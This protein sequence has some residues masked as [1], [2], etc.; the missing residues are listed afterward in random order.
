M[1]AACA[2]CQLSQ[3]HPPPAT[4]HPVVA[5]VEGCA[6]QRLCLDFVGPMGRSRR[7]TSTSSPSVIPLPSGSKLFPAVTPELLMSST[8]SSKKYSVASA[9]H[10]PSILIVGT[11]FVNNLVKDVAAALDIRLT[12]TTAYNPKA[13]PVERAHRDFGAH[14][15]QLS[16]DD[17]RSWDDHVPLAVFAM[18]T[19]LCRT[20]GLAP[21]QALFGR[22]PPTP[23]HILMAPPPSALPEELAAHHP[24]VLRLRERMQQMHAYMRER[25]GAAVQRQRRAYHQDARFYNIGDRVY[26]FTPI[27]VVGRPRKLTEYWTRTLDYCGAFEHA[28]LPHLTRPTLGLPSFDPRCRHRSSQ[29]R[30]TL[31]GV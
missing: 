25:I 4:T 31:A 9:S 27:S 8:S 18:N 16:S 26:L 23:L 2:T 1:L 11:H 3:R 22:D 15:S 17:P 7:G 14:H 24:F 29:A 30:T 5:P 20:T 21:F 12:T 6:F 13:N 10:T 28:H 19:A